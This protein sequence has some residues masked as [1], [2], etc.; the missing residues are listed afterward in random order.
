[1]ETRSSHG[2]RDH[3]GQAAAAAAIAF[4]TSACAALVDV[5]EHV[6][7][8]VGEHGLERLARP[9]VLAADHAGDLDPLVLHR[10]EPGLERLRARASRAR[11]RAEAR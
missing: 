6:R 11:T 4:S 9:D 1:M 3:S 8:A 7:L 2:V 5:G 10:R